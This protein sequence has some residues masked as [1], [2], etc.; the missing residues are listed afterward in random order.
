MAPIRRIKDHFYYK[1]LNSLPQPSPQKSDLNFLH[2][3]IIILD[4]NQIDDIPVI[5]KV[6]GSWNDEGV[7]LYLVCFGMEEED[8]PTSS[9]TIFLTKKD[10]D[11]KGV[12]SHEKLKETVSRRYDVMINLDRTGKR[13]MEFLSAAIFADLKI[14]LV[15]TKHKI[16]DLLVETEAGD[17]R[18]IMDE[19]DSW[20]KTLTS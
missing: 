14:G 7:Q 3:I 1:N 9:D 6:T 20:I 17:T 11:W 18:G 12:P 19:I 8:A 10:I 5:K 4:R 2:K 13:A 15:E 16:Y